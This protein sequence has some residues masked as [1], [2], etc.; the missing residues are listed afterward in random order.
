[1]R[2]FSGRFTRGLCTENDVESLEDARWYGVADGKAP[3]HKHRPGAKLP[4]Y[5]TTPHLY[6]LISSFANSWLA[7]ERAA[8]RSIKPQIAGS[9]RKY[10]TEHH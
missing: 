7:G 1:M 5:L 2:S 8:W 10:D 4:V 6:A 3:D 9:V